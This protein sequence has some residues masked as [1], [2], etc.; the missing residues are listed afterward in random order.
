M[1]W[2]NFLT[3]T[4]QFLLISIPETKL[5]LTLKRPTEILFVFCG[6]S[7]CLARVW[8]WMGRPTLLDNPS[9]IPIMG[10]LSTNSTYMAIKSSVDLCDPVIISYRFLSYEEKIPEY[11]TD[12]MT[13]CLAINKIYFTIYH[14][15]FISASKKFFSRFCSQT[16]HNKFTW[17]VM[18]CHFTVL[19][20]S[21]TQ[22][23]VTVWSTAPLTFIS[24]NSKPLSFTWL[25]RGSL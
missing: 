19:R 4:I 13:C 3:S 6:I 25:L 17:M 24:E 10:Y 16:S 11:G 22:F 21:W 1:F 9:I 2:V 15:F 20:T 7:T 12:Q 5:H 14:F 23:L 18:F 8:Q